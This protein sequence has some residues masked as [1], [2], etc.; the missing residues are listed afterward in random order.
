M[1]RLFRVFVVG[2]VM[3][4]LVVAPLQG[5]AKSRF[6][7]SRFSRTK[8][9]SLMVRWTPIPT[10]S[11][12]ISIVSDNDIVQKRVAKRG[13]KVYAEEMVLRDKTLK[14]HLKGLLHYEQSEGRPGRGRLSPS[15]EI[16]KYW[17]NY[18][19][20]LSKGIKITEEMVKTKSKDGV[21]V[22]YV[23]AES[24]KRKC[25]MYF[26]S[27]EGSEGENKYDDYQ[28]VTGYQCAKP[29]SA[30]ANGLEN[31]MLH[32]VSQ[33]RFDGGQ[34]AK[35]QLINVA[36][37]KLDVRQKKEEDARKRDRE[38]PVFRVPK[39]LVGDAQGAVT[40]AGR[41]K[42]KSKIDMVRI[43]GT[44]VNLNDDGRFEVQIFPKPGQKSMRLVAIDSLG[45]RSK[46]KKI[47]ISPRASGRW[48]AKRTESESGKYY[49]VL[50]GNAEYKHWDDLGTPP[51]DIRTIGDL[52]ERSYGFVNQFRLLDVTG[53][54][55]LETI[56]KLRDVL[57]EKDHLLV[58]YAGHGV[59]A[60]GIGYWVPV[61][62]KMDDPE[63]WVANEAV[64]RALRRLPSRHVIV[65]ADSCY[66]GTI[67]EERVVI[68]KKAR[69]A[70]PS[71]TRTAMSSGSG[72]Q[73][74]LEPFVEEGEKGNVFSV[75]AD[76]FI[77]VLKT[78]R[79]TSISATQIHKRVRGVLEENFDQKPQYGALSSA[80]HDQGDDFL[81]LK[82]L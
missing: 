67:A 23:V 12:A 20:L 11:S 44:W 7:K 57:S 29:K 65:V 50:I 71:W 32:V 79:A 54:Q 17:G 48:V 30:S 58:Y 13:E 27:E 35:D 69:S 75:F 60:S 55:I 31:N 14:G 42:D 62:G 80:G 64:N 34:Y 41:V 38:G 59:K 9:G 4:G 24:A 21:D 8:K 49:A 28:V 39:A 10:A 18:K 51:D 5:V 36:L 2:L 22:H 72:D 76:E 61:D 73:V 66:S 81:F 53:N 77:N 63:K 45:N 3:A 56:R 33:I 47:R 74:V 43:D 16:M 26:R 40:V 68:T 19:K 78:N 1:S 70:L 15:A 6:G 37:K 82:S 52:L 46:P 25:F